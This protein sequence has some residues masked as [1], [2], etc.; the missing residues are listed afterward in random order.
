MCSSDLLIGTLF[1]LLLVFA[2]L[3]PSIASLEPLVSWGQ[4]RFKFSRPKAAVV[5]AGACWLLGIGSVLSFNLWSGWRPLG[6]IPVFADSTLFDVA[7]YLSS[8]VLLPIGALLTSV[9]VGWRVSRS[10]VAEELMETPA[11]SRRLV[12]WLLRYVCPVAI[13]LILASV[14]V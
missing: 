7:D 5:S 12:V 9:F 11:Y 4:Q 14:L 3:T 8:N 1:F 2:A 10:I 6:S 13:A